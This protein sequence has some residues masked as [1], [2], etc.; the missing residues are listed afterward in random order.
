MS[1]RLIIAAAD[2]SSS[3]VLAKRF[4][5][6]IAKEISRCGK[7]MVLTGSIAKSLEFVVATVPREMSK[8]FIYTALAQVGESAL[9]YTSGIGFVHYI[10]KVAKPKKIKVTA[11]VIYNVACLP[12]TLYSKGISATFDILRLSKLEEMWFG[13]P[14]YIF[15]NNRL[16]IESN[17]TMDDIFQHMGDN[18]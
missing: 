4:R 16:W 14:V 7:S 3:P 8:G 6:K 15:N 5:G 12:I 13:E 18:D 9:G 10:Y 17:F 2:I 11:R 1:S